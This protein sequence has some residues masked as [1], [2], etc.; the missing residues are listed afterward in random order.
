[1]RVS[2]ALAS[3]LGVLLATG[4]AANHFSATIPV[5]VQDRGLSVALLDAAFG[6]YAV[7]LL[8]GL[9]LGGGLSDRVGRA[10][11]VLPGALL[12][13]VGTIVLLSWHEPPGL[14]L[15]RFVVGLGAGLAFGAGTAWAADLGGSGGAVLAGIF[16]TTGFGVGPL[17][18]GA[19]AQWG[20]APLELPFLVSLLLSVTAVA[21]AARSGAVAAAA[22]RAAPP[23]PAPT[24]PVAPSPE[25]SVA[26]TLAWSLPV[27]VVVFGSATVALVSLTPR[28]PEGLNGPFFFGVSAMLSLG[29]GIGVQTLARQRGWGPRT[30]V[31]G[32]LASALGFALV[33]IGGAEVG[34]PLFAVVCLVMGVAYGLCLRE[35]LLDVESLAPPTHRGTLIGV[36]YVATYLGF[37]LPLL[38]TLLTPYAGVALP[39]LGFSLLALLLATG[40]TLQL[41]AGHPARA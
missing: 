5:F 32:L 2:R 9:V 4:W 6:L 12:A 16:L 26:T 17:V 10:R 31:V 27:A 35:G 36:F 29:S 34:L 30:G 37:G 38:L 25:H 23:P 24:T 40:R 7:G 8:P 39:A 41:R 13:S 21:V 14:L 22:A 3:V 18:S 19:I 20:P 15:G 1:M 28:L 33:A 11:V